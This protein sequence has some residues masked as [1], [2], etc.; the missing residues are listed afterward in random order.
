M[1]GEEEG[2]RRRRKDGVGMA[3]RRGRGVM[4]LGYGV[5]VLTKFINLVN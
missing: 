1:K 4:W 3:E 5:M 2:G